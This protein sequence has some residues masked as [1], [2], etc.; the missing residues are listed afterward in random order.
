[1]T[2]GPVK[3][4]RHALY[5]V[6]NTSD[7]DSADYRIADYLIRNIYSIADFGIQDVADACFVSKSTVS[8]FCR[9]IGFAD[10]NAVAQSIRNV[11]MRDYKRFDE[12]LD[13]GPQEMTDAYLDQTIDCMLKVREYATPDILSSLAELL[14]SYERIGIFGQMQSHSVAL[15][16]QYELAS[17]GKYASCFSMMPEQE[18]FIMESGADTL[19]IIVSSG[20]KYFQDFSSHVSYQSKDR[21][22][23]VLITN[24][25]RL[26]RCVPYD[27]VYVVPCANNTASRPLSL[28]LF[29]NLAVMHF[30]KLL[31]TR[32][33]ETP[34]GSVH[35]VYV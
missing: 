31:E 10:F 4:L 1:M 9:R 33:V 16:F 20:G 14:F 25:R 6:L 13:L 17:L 30:S 28:Q 22:H 8:R 32:K 12:Y 24:N 21:P 15:N 35:D 26:T 29:A 34:R 27:R 11:Q 18:E 19:V 2:G 7:M 3:K 5:A 23:L